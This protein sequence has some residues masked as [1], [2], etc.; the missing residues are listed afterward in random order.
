MDNVVSSRSRREVVQASGLAVGSAILLSLGEQ[1]AQANKATS[2]QQTH[3]WQTF[4]GDASHTGAI[5]SGTLEGELQKNWSKNVDGA[6]RSSAVASSNHA[7]VTTLD[8]AVIS[9]N[10]ETGEKQWEVSLG[11]EIV[12]SPVLADSVVCVPVRE[13]D[14]YD[15]DTAPLSPPGELVGF[16]LN[17]GDRLW[18]HPFE[19]ELIGAPTLWDGDIFLADTMGILKRIE[20]RT[21]QERGQWE[22][23]EVQLHSPTINQ[24]KIYLQ[25]NYGNAFAVDLSGEE[26]WSNESSA[27]P[28]P[29]PSPGTSVVDLAI[30]QTVPIEAPV[31]VVDE[32][33]ISAGLSQQ[34]TALDRNTGRTLW[35][36]T[37]RGAILSSPAI[38]NDRVFVG[39][40]TG[41]L[42]CLGF[43]S[44]DEI[45]ESREFSQI[46][47]SPIIT[48]DRLFICDQQ[49][50]YQVD[51]SDG[52]IVKSLDL[53]SQIYATPAV[54]GNQLLIGTESGEFYSLI[55]GGEPTVTAA[56][57]EGVETNMIA[58][59]TQ[60]AVNDEIAITLS[61]VN[62]FIENT[63]TVQ[64]L[65]QPPSGVSITGVRGADEGSA[66]MTAVSEISPGEETNISIDVQINEPGQ[67]KIDG[68]LFISTAS[69]IQREIP[70]E[71][72][73]IS[74]ESGSVGSESDQGEKSNSETMPGFGLVESI[75]ALG[76][77]GYALKR[78]TGTDG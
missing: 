22:T 44:G 11:H 62:P 30:D 66:Q 12:G 47:S 46:V 33:V 63:L 61:I 68:L 16:D 6:I 9:F 2:T 67:Y 13:T 37:A 39:D 28:Y 49:Y 8:G 73:S 27:A 64:L 69:G 45:W 43:S 15:G 31:T 35:E 1:T 36:F 18:T 76:G 20:V 57:V 34:I 38:I 55:V 74:T 71:P 52:E 65:L 58:S 51:I 60:V 70:L 4:Q 50:V 26:V 7:V 78:R 42:Y 23:S 75:I 10:L 56:D 77:V 24:D 40:T 59:Q 53:G 5:S 54:Y 3:P 17:D 41:T 19:N 72:V 32:T 25:T 21:G 14:S 29:P 48:R